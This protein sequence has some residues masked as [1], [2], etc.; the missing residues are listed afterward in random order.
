M[1]WPLGNNHQNTAIHLAAQNGWNEVAGHLL[2]AKKLNVNKKDLHANTALH[3]AAQNGQLGVSFGNL[4]D[5]R[6]FTW[7][8]NSLIDTE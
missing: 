4:K 2:R 3:L 8:Q 6:I 5:A 1:D 7:F